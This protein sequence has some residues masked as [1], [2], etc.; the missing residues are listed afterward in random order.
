[1]PNITIIFINILD[2]LISFIENY[3]IILLVDLFFKK[4]KNITFLFTLFFTIVSVL[5]NKIFYPPIFIFF[6]L[7]V[8]LYIYTF[9]CMDGTVI[10]K[11][12]IPLLVFS[13]VF[14]I[15]AITSLLF[16]L[17]TGNHGTF[18]ASLNVEYFMISVFQ[19]FL[20]LFEYLTIKKYKN[21]DIYITN[22]AWILSFFIIIISMAFPI[23]LYNEY[24][25]NIISSPLIVVMAVIEFTIVNILIYSLLYKIN[26]D[27]KKITEQQILL[28]TRK[29]EEQLCNFI[30]ERIIEMNKINHDINH[31]MLVI[32][33]MVAEKKDDEI[34]SYIKKVFSC[35]SNHSVNTNNKIVNYLLNEKINNAQKY[36]I[37]VKC[38]IQG[39]LEDVLSPVDLSIVLGNL[40]DNAIEGA[41]ESKEKY[42]D[43]NIYRN[44]YIL[45]ISVINSCCE[46]I[47]M[48]GSVFMT[49]K[50]ESSKHGYGLSNIKYVCEKY[51]GYNLAEYSNNVFSHICTFVLI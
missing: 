28:E 37:D 48:K 36:Q 25:K 41:K 39:D 13:N 10:K 44:Q 14:I 3:L 27:N 31:Y 5:V 19:K 43:I 22:S 35:V 1:M 30:D 49:T 2:I 18:I 16:I 11:I 17:L 21:N 4:N 34:D 47:K 7:L 40:L 24:L 20:L 15:N 8:L 50:K 32:K 38:L 12:V 45:K 46:N 6:V 29:Y 9:V 51:K 26:S 42:I 23:I 33:K